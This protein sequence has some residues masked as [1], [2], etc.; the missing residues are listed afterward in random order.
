MRMRINTLLLCALVSAPAMAQSSITGARVTCENGEAAGHPCHDVVLLSRL[1]PDRLETDAVL[2]MWGWT[3]R[4]SGREYALVATEVS[5]AFVDISDPVNPAYLGQLPSH[6]STKSGWRDLKVYQDHAFVVVDGDGANGLQVFDLTQLRSPPGV[7]YVFAQSAHYDQFGQAHNVAIN[8]ETGFAYVVGSNTGPC[9]NGL[10]MVDIRVP[11]QPAYAGCFIDNAT[12]SS[13]D[14]YTHDAQCVIYRGPDAEHMGKEICIGANINGV[15]I[16]D[17]SDKAQPI[18]IAS[19]EYPEALYAHQA[20]LTEDQ[21][22]LFLNDETD[23]LNRHWLNLPPLPGTRTLIWDLVDLDDPV[24]H[25]E[26][27]GPTGS[28]DHNLYIR[29]DTLYMANYASGLR[30]VDISA[31]SAP[32]EVAH[33]DTYPFSDHAGLNGAWT[34]YPYYESGTIA[35]TSGHHGLFLVAYDASSG[36]ASDKRATVP[37]GFSLTSAYPNPFNP[38][39]ML[40]LVNPVPQHVAVK[41]HDLTGRTVAVLH[42]GLLGAGTHLLRF[43]GQALPS[44]TYLVVATARTAQVTQAV[45]LAK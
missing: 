17:V 34:A 26:Y 32:V 14:G 43:D 12:G 18:K 36:T 21:R 24:L 15:S 5:V 23:E 39:T 31:P 10:H 7:P 38:A 11:L 13:G 30:I 9:P 6:D 8:T 33:F 29:G 4:A 22:Y 45:T 42:E 28:S 1:M 2:D 44:G 37:T 40:S 3:D 25:H 27:F 19:A 35:I 20:W 16:A 41:A